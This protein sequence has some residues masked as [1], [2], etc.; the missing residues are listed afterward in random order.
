MLER[1]FR[2]AWSSRGQVQL[3]PLPQQQSPPLQ[4]ALPSPQRPQA[5][6][7]VR[8]HLEPRWSWP[9]NWVLQSPSSKTRTS[10]SRLLPGSS[11]VRTTTAQVSR[12]KMRIWMIWCPPESFHRGVLSERLCAC[13]HIFLEMGWET[14]SFGFP[15]LFL[16]FSYFFFF[17]RSSVCK[18]SITGMTFHIFSFLCHFST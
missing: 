12:W 14:S 2:N 4:P 11:R 16:Y 9:P 3:P 6:G 15:F 8:S 18:K 5:R 1:V 7:Q 17:H 10:T 13:H